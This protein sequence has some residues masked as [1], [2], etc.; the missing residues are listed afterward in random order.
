MSRGECP[1]PKEDCR[2]ERPFSDW[3][4]DHWP[5]ADYEKAGVIEARWRDLAINGLQL[6]RCIHND[7]H[8]EDAPPPMPDR[9]QMVDDLLASDEHMTRR[10]KR[11]LAAAVKKR[12]DTIKSEV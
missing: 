11:A 8:A 4:H 1:A 6:C 10:V 12:I 5:R 7:I 2:Q 9:D 3:H